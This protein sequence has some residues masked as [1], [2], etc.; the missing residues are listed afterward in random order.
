MW[1]GIDKRRFPRVHFQC[2]V[3]VRSKGH[4]EIFSTQTENIGVGGTCVILE[5]GLGLFTE[6]EVEI[7]LSDK[8]PSLVSEGKVVWVVKHAGKQNYFDTGIEFVNLK[9]KDKE[10]INSLVQQIVTSIDN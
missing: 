7:V 8:N 3:I 10:R 1:E 6:V 9:Q 2:Q 4:P 5:K